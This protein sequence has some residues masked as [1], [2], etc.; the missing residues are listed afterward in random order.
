MNIR[1]SPPPPRHLCVYVCEY[2][3]VPLYL[4]SARDFPSTLLDD[5]CLLNY[6]PSR[7]SHWSAQARAPPALPAAKDQRPC[8]FEYRGG[9]EAYC[10]AASASMRK[11]GC[12]AYTMCSFA[13]TQA[14]TRQKSV[15]DIS[16]T[17]THYTSYPAVRRREVH[18]M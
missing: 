3:A 4:A 5:A 11:G 7:A 18:R 15:Y 16:I 13:R 1:I 9:I 2:G 10:R 8:N 6:H 17:Y 12:C 14:S